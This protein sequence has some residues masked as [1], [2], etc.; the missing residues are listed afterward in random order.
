[1]EKYLQ[2]QYKNFCN[3]YGE[4][5]IL[6][7][8]AAP[9]YTEINQDIVSN[10][11]ISA[12]YLPIEDE[13]YNIE[14]HKELIDIRNLIALALDKNSTL[15]NSLISSYRYIN[16]TYKQYINDEFFIYLKLI[17]FDKDEIIIDK[18]KNIIKNLILYNMKEVSQEQQLLN[19]L[20]KT[21]LKVLQYIIKD[22]NNQSE[23]DIKVSQA[24]EQYK[25]S[26]SVFR[27]LFYKL[28][29]YGVAAI[30]SRGVKGTH[31]VFKN[32]STLKNLID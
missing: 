10:K 22:F 23:G 12:Y 17:I 6:W 4:N 2:E 7:I 21:E 30:D 26:T 1:M 8:A 24:T 32:I 29:E 13:L 28:K 11:P 19:I 20:T 9:G 3:K 25:I 16:P 27:T 18:V 31:I 14:P 5:R 15:L